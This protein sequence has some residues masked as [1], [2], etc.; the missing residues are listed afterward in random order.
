MVKTTSMMFPEVESFLRT[1][2]GESV[3][4]PW[5][6]MPSDR[7]KVTPVPPGA[8]AKPTPSST[9]AAVTER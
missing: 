9:I 5:P 8:P 6:E 1:M 7:V 3:G 2:V 4:L